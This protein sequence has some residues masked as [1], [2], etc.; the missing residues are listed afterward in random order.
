MDQSSQ[1]HCLETKK[2][3]VLEGRE[4]TKCFMGIAEKAREV[5]IEA[6]SKE[7]KEMLEGFFLPVSSHKKVTSLLWLAWSNTMHAFKFRIHNML[8]KHQAPGF[9]SEGD[10][11]L[12]F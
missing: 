3:G 1:F 8:S 6:T 4:E 5:I 2:R 11:A 7:G 9:F 10:V 12:L